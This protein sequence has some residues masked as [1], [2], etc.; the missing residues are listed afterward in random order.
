MCKATK[1]QVIQ[2]GIDE[3]TGLEYEF[4]TWLSAWEKKVR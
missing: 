3:K 4:I 1:T 2:I